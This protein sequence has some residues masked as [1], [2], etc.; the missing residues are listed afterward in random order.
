MTLFHRCLQTLFMGWL[1]FFSCPANADRSAPGIAIIMAPGSSQTRL[2]REELLLI[3]KSKKQFWD[4]GQR[5]RAI[6]LPAHHPLR[7][8]F[9]MAVLKQS[10]EE[11]EDYWSDMYFHGVLPPYVFNSEE[12]VIRF[13]AVTPGA[14]G[15][16]SHCIVDHRVIVILQLDSGYSCQK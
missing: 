16:V 7:Y 8:A 3:F 15:Y 2:T 12:A 4:D 14:I 6:N 11:M 13:V 5:I 9:S 1:I 10:S